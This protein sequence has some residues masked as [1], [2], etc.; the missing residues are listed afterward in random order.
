VENEE[1]MKCGRRYFIKIEMKTLITYAVGYLWEESSI[2]VDTLESKNNK[3][4]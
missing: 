4:C 2:I 1:N 3:T